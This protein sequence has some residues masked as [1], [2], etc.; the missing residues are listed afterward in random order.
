MFGSLVEFI[1]H[2]NVV[3]EVFFLKCGDQIVKK[4]M[5]ANID[6]FFEGNLH[7]QQARKYT[8]PI[9]KRKDV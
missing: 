2:K 8:L 7:G 6:I 5:V 1:L 4:L 3:H 9:C